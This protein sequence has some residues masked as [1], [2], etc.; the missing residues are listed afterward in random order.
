V[1]GSR[2]DRAAEGAIEDAALAMEGGVDD[3]L[4]EECSKGFEKRFTK[5]GGGSRGP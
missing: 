3:K 2:T 1:V 4:G 5:G